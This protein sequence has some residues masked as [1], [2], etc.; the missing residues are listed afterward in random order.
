MKLISKQAV[1][2]CIEISGFVFIGSKSRLILEYMFT[3]EAFR[4]T[5]AC[6]V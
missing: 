4:K 3:I 2:V 1:M 6:N 5:D